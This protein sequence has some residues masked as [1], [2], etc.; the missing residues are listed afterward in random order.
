MV[1]ISPSSKMAKTNRNWTFT[2]NK[3]TD[4]EITCIKG[5]NETK[6]IGFGREVAPT[7][8]TPHLHVLVCFETP[9]S[10]KQIL[11]VVRRA[12]K[13]EP[14]YVKSTPVKFWEYCQK[15]DKDA[16]SQGTLPTE[17]RP[18]LQDQY[19]ETLAFARAGDL[20]SIRPSHLLRHLP[21]ILSLSRLA[22][23][24]KTSLPRDIICGVWIHGPSGTGKTQLALKRF[25]RLFEVTKTDKWFDG[26][27]STLHDS[28]LFDD[29]DESHRHLIPLFN[30]YCNPA[31]FAVQ[32]KG[33]TQW[34]RPKNIVVTSRLSILEWT[35][36]GKHD[37]YTSIRRRFKLWNIINQPFAAEFPPAEDIDV[38][39]WD[40]TGNEAHEQEGQ[41][42]VDKIEENGFV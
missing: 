36:E 13:V 30:T 22:R 14:V 38:E 23:D 34:I 10:R 19:A 20:E 9:K 16:W 25:P 37:I 31:A 4:A 28:L 24:V 42:G 39:R 18:H 41:A 15:D 32:V 33:G 11:K 29:V 17:E 2:L 35:A 12:A 7:T 8:G 27:D 5:F 3:Y 21:N 40:G 6:F 1:K 26:Y